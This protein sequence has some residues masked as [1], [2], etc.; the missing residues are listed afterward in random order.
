MQAFYKGIRFIKCMN[1]VEIL[2]KCFG[3][4]L[5]FPPPNTR[6]VPALDLTKKAKRSLVV[7]DSWSEKSPGLVKQTSKQTTTTTMLAPIG[8]FPLPVTVISG[9][10]IGI[11]Y[12]KCNYPGGDY[13]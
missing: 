3:Q 12:S 2:M 7:A 8:L 6:V 4:T 11:P 5:G 10:L 9:S 13:Y 1:H